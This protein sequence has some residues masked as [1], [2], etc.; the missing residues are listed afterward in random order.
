M[1]RGS[2][3][4]CLPLADGLS[5]GVTGRRHVVLGERATSIGR[6]PA[7]SSPRCYQPARSSRPRPVEWMRSSVSPKR[8][9][10]V[11]I[12]GLPG[13]AALRYEPNGATVVGRHDEHALLRRLREVPALGNAGQDVVLRRVA[14]SRCVPAAEL[15]ADRSPKRSLEN[16]AGRWSGGREAAARSVIDT[17]PERTCGK[18]SWM[19]LAASTERSKRVAPSLSSDA[20]IE[21]DVSIT[22]N[23][24][25]SVR[26]FTERSVPS[27]GCPAAIPRSRGRRRSRRSAGPGATRGS[28]SRSWLRIRPARRSRN[29]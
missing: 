23:T 22:K 25:A 6:P 16:L 3:C 10:T 26:S 14:S 13:N 19:A 20:S 18:R 7:P 17:M 4:R 1:R 12:G 5:N 8:T 21:R 27:T 11:S 24:S 2:S 15:D 29:Q 28:S 9:S